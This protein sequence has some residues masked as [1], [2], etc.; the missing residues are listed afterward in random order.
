MNCLP[1]VIMRP[2]LSDTLS[3]QLP[4]QMWTSDLA[5]YTGLHD[6]LDSGHWKRRLLEY[7]VSERRFY[8]RFTLNND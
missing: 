6:R 5:D 8:W 3:R 1:T 7:E 4:T 2:I